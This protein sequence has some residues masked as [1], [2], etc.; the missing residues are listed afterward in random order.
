MK[1]FINLLVLMFLLINLVMPAMPAHAAAVNLLSNPSL[2]TSTA[3]LPTDW[4]SNNWGTNTS[5]FTYDATGFTGSHSVSVNISAYTSGDAKWFAKPVAITGGK[6]YTYSDYYKSG[7]ATRVV[8]AFQ[9]AVGAYTYIELGPAT[10]SSTWA[11]YST[12]LTAPSS[13]SQ[14]AIYHLLDK[15]GSLSIDDASLVE[16]VVTPPTDADN[17]VANNSLE[18]VNGTMPAKWQS[19]KW[20]TNTSTFTYETTGRTGSRSATVKTTAYTSGDAKWYFDPATVTAG[21]TYLYRD[22]YKSTVATNLVAAFIDA[23]GNYIYKDLTAAPTATAWTLYE[24]NFVIPTG[25]VKASV[26]HYL[27][28][29]GSLTI[30][31]V[32]LQVA[33]PTVP[34]TDVPNGTLQAGTTNPDFWQKSKWGNNTAVF[35]YRNDG[36]TTASNKSVRVTVSNYVDGD[37]KWYFDPIKTLTPGQQY[38]FTAWYK[39]TVIPHAVAMFIMADGSERYV[40]MPSPLSVSSTTWQKY[41]DTFTVPAGAVSSTAFLYV[42]SNGWV[43]TDDYSLATY[44]PNGYSRPL[45]TLTFDDGHEDNATTALPI[46]NKYGFK[47]TQCYATTFIEGQ[48]QTVKNGVLAF[49]NSGHEICSHTVTHPF[50]TT[51]SAVNLDYE[52]KHS[53]EY[54]ESLTGKTVVDFASPYG[55]YNA[56]VNTAIGKYYQSHRTVDEGFN[57]KDNF[58]PYRLRVQNILD[59]T[60]AAQV[61]AWVDQ[62]QLDKTWLV[63]VY[64]RIANNPG[65]Y[66]AT[67]ANFDAQM[68]V[69]KTSGIVVQTM[70]ASLAEVRAQP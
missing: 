32:L 48:S 29:V 67:I 49:S 56:N 40:G 62:A 64:H 39:G 37:A 13:A 22:Y 66:D 46:M 2:E 41:S 28:A 15:Q 6:S 70:Q 31:D 43:Q 33:V 4:Q 35:A 7:V 61:K 42:N 44:V 3:N 59:T 9:D 36:H 21:K 18:T 38:R 8:A 63:L 26:Y 57:S 65:P 69:I 16:I 17:I 25:T 1:R 47:S 54:L 50:L 51:L 68:K 45:V 55:D 14:V 11:Q 53:K 34:S 19:N 60:T 52:L 30:D 23:N 27:A 12:D 20:G 5:T 10:A 24:T 58:D